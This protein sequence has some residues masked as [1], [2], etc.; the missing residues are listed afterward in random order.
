MWACV[1][2]GIR[3]GLYYLVVYEYADD[4]DPMSDAQF[5]F[6]HHKETVYEP[7]NS[8]RLSVSRLVKPLIT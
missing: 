6:H 4:R 2:G 8:G 5:H 3:H 7:S 1:R